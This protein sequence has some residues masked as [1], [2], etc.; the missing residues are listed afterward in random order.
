MNETQYKE[1]SIE[2]ISYFATYAYMT[3]LFIKIY[4]KDSYII[5][6][7]L[8][9]ES[10]KHNIH[11]LSIIYNTLIKYPILGFQP[12]HFFMYRLYENSYKNYHSYYAFFKIIKINKNKPNLLN[13]KFTFKMYINDKIKNP[14]LIA[15]FNYSTRKITHYNKP[16][17]EKVVIKPTKN[18]G[19]IGIKILPAEKYIKTLKKC[20]KSYIAED[21]IKQHTFINEIFSG[22]VNTIRI[23]TLKKNQDFVIIKAILR[24]GR[25]S[26]QGKDNLS[27][28]GISISID[29]EKGVLGRGR[30]YY[31]YGDVE[32]EEHPD[33]KYRFYGKKLPYFNE[34]KDLALKAHKYFPMLSFI[35][36]D[37]AITETGPIIVEGNSIPGLT[38]FQLHEPLKEK[39]FLDN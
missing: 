22:S 33:T 16:T 6:K 3:Y 20:H 18:D 5:L 1:K 31:Q 32:Y 7:N 11:L 28:G 13:N 24:M 17:T 21:Y 37:I 15:N 2:K 12:T 29:M 26:T 38:G 36:W 27:Q 19:G 23:L 10:K 14:K 4:I 30:Q 35:G 9:K 34:I 8:K 25:V 39:L